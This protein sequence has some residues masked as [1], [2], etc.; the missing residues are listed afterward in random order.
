MDKFGGIV[1]SMILMLLGWGFAPF[2]DS[3]LAAF[4]IAILFT[5]LGGAGIVYFTYFGK[6]F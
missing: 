3:P 2:N 1:F 6:D 4:W 5:V